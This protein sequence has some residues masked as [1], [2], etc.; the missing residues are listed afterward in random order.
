MVLRP[1]RDTQMPGQVTIQHGEKAMSG[2]HAAGEKARV[3]IIVTARERFGMAKESIDSIYAETDVPFELVVI[4]GRSPA[5]LSEWLDQESAKRGFRVVRRDRFVTPNEARNLGAAVADTEFVAFVDNDVFYAPNWLSALLDA[6]DDTG[7]EIITP[8]TC[9]GLPLHTRVHHVT[10]LYTDDKEAFFAAPHG[11]RELLDVMHHHKEPLAKVQ[12]E[13]KRGPAD[14][15]EFH[16]VLVR[17]S[18]LEKVGRLDENIQCTKDHLDFSMVA[19]LAGGRIVS[20]PKSVVTYVFPSRA[21][22]M[23]A[24]DMPYF[25]LRWSPKWQRQD[26]A[27]L[28]NKWGLTKGGEI[29]E[30]T[31]PAYMRMRHFQGVVNPTIRKIPVVR[32]S[33]KLTKL[34]GWLIHLYLNAKVNLLDAEFRKQRATEAAR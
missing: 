30:V 16:C 1:D 5:A 27:Y 34:A 6:A 20:E 13:L 3:T 33:Y 25:L 4:D 21:N 14:T 15:C 9:E 32:S 28:R 18:F 11:E 31:D 7:A 12:G 19:T 10:T 24:D 29:E 22:P 23:T 2:R 17:R 26:L 8:L